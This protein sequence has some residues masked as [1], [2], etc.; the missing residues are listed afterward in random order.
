M[1]DQDRLT[2]VYGPEDPKSDFLLVCVVRD[3]MYFLPEFLA[4]YRAL[5]VEHFVFLDD[6]S[7]DGT[8]DLLTAQPDVSVINAGLRFSDP[9]TTNNANY[10]PVP[11]R[12]INLWRTLL[13]RRFQ[14]RLGTVNADADE[15]LQL[16][17]GQK[18]RDMAVKLDEGQAQ[19]VWGSMIDVYPEHPS[20]L[21]KMSHETRVDPSANWQFDAV[22][23]LKLRGNATPKELYHGAK[24]RLL[25]HFGVFRVRKGLLARAQ[26]K[27]GFKLPLHDSVQKPVFFQNFGDH[28]F[29]GGHK[30]S[31]PGHP[32]LLLPLVHYKFSGALMNR[33]RAAISEKTHYQGSKAYVQIEK[34]LER[35]Q[36]QNAPFSCDI[37]QPVS[38]ENLVKS[39]NLVFDG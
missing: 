37:S 26:R 32:S 21:E 10:Q 25:E 39:G 9:V 19:C 1:F 29:F 27:A 34:L 2:V 4:H 30:S 11:Q 15:F 35:M 22:P 7:T 33:V 28:Q 8:M 38:V 17:P 24:A 6:A 3:E 16:P 36:K 20:E 14:G 5:G 12:A 18:L 31:V 23:H 13:H